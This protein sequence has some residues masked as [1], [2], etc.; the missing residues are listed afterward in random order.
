MSL[1]IVLNIILDIVAGFGMDSPF[2]LFLV[3]LLVLALDLVEM[4]NR[5]SNEM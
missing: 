5:R 2:Y 1:C 3:N 4:D